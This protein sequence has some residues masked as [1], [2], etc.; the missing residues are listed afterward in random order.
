MV[1]AFG[2]HVQRAEGQPADKGHGPGVQKRQKSPH[3]G[4]WDMSSA[5]SLQNHHH[6]LLSEATTTVGPGKRVLKDLEFVFVS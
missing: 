6:P 5:S 1:T 3:Q 4:C 2:H